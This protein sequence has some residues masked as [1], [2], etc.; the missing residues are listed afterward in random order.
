MY[1][2]CYGCLSFF[3]VLAVSCNGQW[4]GKKDTQR[5]LDSGSSFEKKKRKCCG[6]MLLCTARICHSYWFNK[7]ISLV[8]SQAGSVGKTTRLGEFWK[9][10]KRVNHQPEAEN[11]IKMLH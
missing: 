4:S 10:D 5:R 11:K 1:Y 7:K 2:E 9:E 8:Y 3:S 6:I